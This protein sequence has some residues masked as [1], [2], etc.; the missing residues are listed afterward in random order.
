MNL[1]TIAIKNT[2][3]NLFRTLLTI[4]GVAVAMLAFLLLRTVLSAWLVGVEFSAKDRLGT[5]HK[6][7]FIMTLPKR[8]VEE[9]R[10]VPGVSAVTWFNW[11]GGR[12]PGRE[13][14]FFGS[15]AID[16]K[17]F[18]DVYDEVALP[19]E[20]KAKFMQNRR[21]VIV[22]ETLARNMAW[23][24]GDRVT[25]EGTIF[26]GMWEFEIDGI[27]HATRKSFDQSSL[28]FHWDYLNESQPEVQREQVGWIS[29]KV[30]DAGQAATVAKRI[31]QLFD[32]RDI[33]TIS[34]SERA[35]NTSFMGMI[36]TLLDA[37]QIVSLVILLIMML[38]LGNTIAMGVRERTHE[39]GVLRAIGFMPKHLSA[40]VL[41]EA[42]VL[43]LLGGGLGV[44]VGV[45]LINEAIGRYVEETFTGLFPY[46]RVLERDAI[47]AITLSVVLAIAAAAIPAYQAGK[48]N[49]T[50]ALRKFG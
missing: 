41:G 10:E 36:S 3:R 8:Y 35:M 11:F 46:F 30:P 2:R 19:P 49:V 22:G 32:P 6:I 1:A 42:S 7:T 27:Y 13:D 26:P 48:L 24:V 17:T 23:K 31:D 29:S 4:V 28:Y 16:P 21:G 20:Q 5:R 39:Y 47:M 40:F 18:F 43:G 12:V 15:M 25:L 14:Q 38:I 44:A 9:V 37:M 50:D 33:Q 45:P 34:M